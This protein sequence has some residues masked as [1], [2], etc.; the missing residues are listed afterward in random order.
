MNPTAARRI[1]RWQAV[2]APCSKALPVAQPMRG[3]C[4]DDRQ[5]SVWLRSFVQISHR[6]ASYMHACW[7]GAVTGDQDN[8]AG[9]YSYIILS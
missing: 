8:Q 5:S 1:G 6:Q 2:G 9:F 4:P 3:A 7:L